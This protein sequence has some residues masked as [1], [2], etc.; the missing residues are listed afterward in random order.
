MILKFTGIIIV[1]SVVYMMLKREHA[2]YA[3]ILELCVVLFILL[4][5]FP[6]YQRLFEKIEEY[7]SDLQFSVNYIAVLTKCCGYTVIAR[8]LHALCQ[9]A[10]EN[11]LAVKIDYAAKVLILFTAFP[12]FESLFELIKGLL[13]T[14]L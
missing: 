3:F 5:V 13:E 10:G 2:E 11:A 12:V 14:Y 1:L 9:D 8:L 7:M 4:A 6:Y